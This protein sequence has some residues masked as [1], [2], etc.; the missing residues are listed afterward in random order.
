MFL[1]LVGMAVGEEKQ[2]ASAA[3]QP[4]IRLNDTRTA[5][6][7]LPATEERKSITGTSVVVMDKFVVKGQSGMPMGPLKEPKPTGPF[8]LLGGGR[9]FRADMKGARIEV[10]MWPYVD[11]L[12]DDARFKPP[13]LGVAMDFLRISW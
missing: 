4:R 6:V 7:I 10:G 12:A 13:R 2:S 8:S 3:P 11:I 9:F 1:L 5:P